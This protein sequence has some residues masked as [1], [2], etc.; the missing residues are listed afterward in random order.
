VKKDDLLGWSRDTVNA[1]E[2]YMNTTVPAHRVETML[3]QDGTLTLEHLPFRAG[4][5]VE[6]IVLPQPAGPP[7]G[8]LYPLRGL[9]VTYDRPTDPV[10]DGDWEAAR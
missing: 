10:A 9:V 6:V 4:Q 7:P 3:T 1:R 5:A 8:N 2:T